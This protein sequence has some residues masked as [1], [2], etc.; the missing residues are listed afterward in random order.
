MNP[1]DIRIEADMAARLRDA[2]EAH[3]DEDLT[4]DMIEGETRLIDMLDT[5]AEGYAEDKA[6]AEA[7]KLRLDDLS[8]RRK[9]IEA[10]A[11]ARK[12][13]MEKA[14]E[15][16]GIPKI[17]RPLFTASMRALPQSVNVTDPEAIPDAFCRIKR[18]PDKTAIKKAI[19]EGQVI[20]GCTLTNGGQSLSIRIK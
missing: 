13:L 20:P 12:A 4:L 16:A 18:E 8:T 10:R 6:M 5:L 11:D 3:G 15:V 14:L 1:Q 2:L 7:I 9:R 17:E 19:Q